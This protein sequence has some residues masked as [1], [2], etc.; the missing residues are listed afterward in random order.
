[1]GAGGIGSHVD[2]AVHPA[3]HQEFH[4]FLFALRIAAAVT[5]DDRVIMPA[6]NILHGRNNGGDEGVAE[7]GND[8]ADDAG[9]LCLQAAGHF[10][11]DIVQLFDRGLNQ[12]PVLLP[13]GSAVEVL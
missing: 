5:Y 1:M 11:G 13:D 4:G 2:Q 12:Q 3:V 7:L 10:I 6:K 8:H 9:L